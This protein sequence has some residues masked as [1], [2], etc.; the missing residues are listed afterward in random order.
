M[1]KS[2]ARKAENRDRAFMRHMLFGKL[3]PAAKFI[4]NEDAVKGVHKL[5]DDIKTILLQKHPEARDVKQAALLPPNDVEDPEPVIYE[6][7]GSELVQKIS[8]KLKGSGGPS[9]VDADMW[10][11]FTG[12]KALGKAPEQLCVAIAETAKILCTEPVHPDC[13]EEYNACRLIPLD[14][15]ATKD[16][17][18]GVRPI[19]VGE[20][21][22]R[23]IGKL[24]IHVIK[25]DITI[26][27][28]PLQ[29]CS[30]GKGWY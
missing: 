28:G 16:G 7:I 12:S 26:A 22:R 27:A 23:L 5:N 2:L 30:G 13:L 9:Q 20:V 3:G 14:K 1:K 19:G 18:P 21:L 11:D 10:R 17:T 6:E 29:T 25:K 15:G 24:L 4:N 8:K